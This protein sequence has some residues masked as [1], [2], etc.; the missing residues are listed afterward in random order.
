MELSCPHDISMLKQEIFLLQ[1]SNKRIIWSK[2]CS[3][4]F[5]LSHKQ[6][7]TPCAIWY[8]LYNLKNVKNTH[9]E[10]LL[11]VKAEA[12][13]FTKSKTPFTISTNGNK[14]RKASHIMKGFHIF[15]SY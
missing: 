15:L 14:P 11:L 2:L 9:G 3:R 12:C 7:V 13:N 1:F 10:K 4:R 6:Y 5:T 8:H